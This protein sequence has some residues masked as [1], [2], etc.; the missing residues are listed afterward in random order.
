MANRG[1]NKAGIKEQVDVKS[2]TFVPLKA[3]AG[4]DVGLI[5]CVSVY[6]F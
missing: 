6:L 1:G 3:A 5:V 4:T 2:P